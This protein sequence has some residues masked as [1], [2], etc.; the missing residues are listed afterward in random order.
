[1]EKSEHATFD[2]SAATAKLDQ[3]LNLVVNAVDAV[4][5]GTFRSVTVAGMR[6]GEELLPQARQLAEAR[7]LAVQPLFSTDEH[8]ADLLVE[9]PAEPAR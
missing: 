9:R 6:F 4:A 2:A 3:E 1:V 5:A 7:G 8:G